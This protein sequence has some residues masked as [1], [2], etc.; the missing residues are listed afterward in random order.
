MLLL[1]SLSTFLSLEYGSLTIFS[2]KV[3]RAGGLMGEGLSSLLTHLFARIGTYLIVLILLVISLM[4]T[5]GLSVLNLS[6]KIYNA[7]KDLYGKAKEFYL[8]RKE[9]EEKTQVLKRKIEI[10]SKR[11]KPRVEE[12][13]KPQKV[14]EFVQDELDFH[15]TDGIYRLPAVT[16][17]D[18]PPASERK[19]SREELLMN[20]EILEKKLADFGVHGQVTEVHP[21]PV[22][23][24]YE[25]QPAAGIKVSKI[26][27]LADDLTMAMRAI[28]V[29]IV[30]PLTG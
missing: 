24:M 4:I 6:V 2:Q 11:P 21:G 17:L 14:L 29:R 23:T 7:T 27:N 1:L 9:K 30:E 18:D 25:Y 28:R 3:Y 5:T 16:L 19:A 13:K 22:V 10:K 26:M 20:S 15:A 12:E 8:N